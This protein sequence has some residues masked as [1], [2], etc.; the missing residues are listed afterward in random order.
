MV[1]RAPEGLSIMPGGGV[2]PDNAASILRRTGAREVHA[3]ARTK[4]STHPPAL[5]R[6]GFVGNPDRT[7]DQAT[8]RALKTAISAVR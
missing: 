5:Q 3:S 1:A 6:L 8:V 2:T 4:I 7:T